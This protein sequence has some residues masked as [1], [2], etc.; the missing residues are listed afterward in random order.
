MKIRRATLALML[1]ALAACSITPQSE[2][3]DLSGRW[4]LTT[5]SKVGS[6]DVD[7]LVRQ[8]GH[9]LEGTVVSSIGEMPCTGRIDGKDVTFQ[10]TL[11]A[12]GRD[13]RINYVGQVD[14]DT[15][16]GKTSFD[17][18]GQGSFAAHRK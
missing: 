2:Q 10:F 7:L 16:T 9:V 13:L 12:A 8:S 3:R 1:S 17:A 6:Q 5:T 11:R 18:F 4:L 15:M 14:G